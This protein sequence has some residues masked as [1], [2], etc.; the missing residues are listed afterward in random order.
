MV[1]AFN[2][3]IAAKANG[4]GCCLIDN[5]AFNTPVDTALSHGIPVIAYNADVSPGTKNNRMAY[6]GQ[7]NLTAGAAV[8]QEILKHVTV[9]RP[10]RR[11]HRDA[12]D[13]E[14]PA[15]DRRR[16]A[17]PDR[18][19]RQLRRGRHLG[20]RGRAGVQQDLRVVRRPQ[21][22]EVHDGRRQRRQQRGRAVHQERASEGQGRRVGLGRRIA[23]RAGHQRRLRD[24]HDRPAGLPA[25]L[26]H[27]HAA[28]PVER[29]GRADEA[30]E[31]RHGTRHRHQGERRAVP[32]A[33]Q[34]RGNVRD[35]ED[36]DAAVHDPV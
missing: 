4:I 21:G 16:E 11:D 5:T 33:E 8:G 31:H 36:T 14:H 34:V 9:G 25:G 3:A 29:L 20:D 32:G 10:R 35:E 7:N 12:G 13:G 18:R 19:R 6:V 23:G 30:D 26:R 28:V 15:A 27:D 17:G 1:S 24:R 22:R 2:T